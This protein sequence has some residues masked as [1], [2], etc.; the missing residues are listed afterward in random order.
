MTPALRGASIWPGLLTAVLLMTA[1]DMDVVT[2]AYATR[3]E[4]EK[5]GAFARGWIPN[6]IPPSA[7]DLREAHSVDTNQRWGLFDFNPADGAGLRAMLEP[8]EVSLTGTST[9]IPQRI[10]WWPV[11]LRTALDDAKLKAAG[12][13]AYRSSDRQLIVIVNW[14]QGRAY[15]WSL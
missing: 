6:G 10:E 12:L 2:E 8:S 4:A 7:H 5:A 11:L 13:Q 15:Y 14:A 1:C 3:A 9:G